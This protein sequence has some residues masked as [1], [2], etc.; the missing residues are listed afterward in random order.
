MVARHSVKIQDACSKGLREILKRVGRINSELIATAS[1][2]SAYSSQILCSVM[3]NNGS[4]FITDA[5]DVP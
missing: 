2:N 5:F 4:K 3:R 1:S